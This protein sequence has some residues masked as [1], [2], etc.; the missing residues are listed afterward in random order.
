MCKWATHN[1]WNTKNKRGGLPQFLFYVH[2]LDSNP[3][4]KSV[5]EEKAQQTSVYKDITVVQIN[6]ETKKTDTVQ[7]K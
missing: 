3:S 7:Y 2:Y 6:V 5:M 1:V 4:K